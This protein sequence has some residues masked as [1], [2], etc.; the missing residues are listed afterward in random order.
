MDIGKGN[1]DLG[2]PK[3]H[4]TKQKLVM[5]YVMPLEMQADLFFS[6]YN[7]LRAFYLTYLIFLLT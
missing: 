5:A 7:C 4:H 6:K 2:C 3:N 1:I